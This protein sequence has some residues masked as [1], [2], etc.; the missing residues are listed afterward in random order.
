MASQL[1]TVELLG[2]DWFV[3][4]RLR[5]FRS[6]AKVGEQIVFLK[7]REMD[8]MLSVKEIIDDR[9]KFELSDE[10]LSMLRDLFSKAVEGD[11]SS[12]E[13]IS[14]ICNQESEE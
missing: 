7:S 11:R 2:K 13:E 6:A 3:D 1:S 12:I 8:D 10:T 9:T 4:E 5:E 14:K